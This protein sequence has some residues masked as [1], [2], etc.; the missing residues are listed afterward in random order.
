[1]RHEANINAQKPKTAC[2]QL[3]PVEHLSV[4]DRIAEGGNIQ[5]IRFLEGIF[6]YN[7]CRANRYKGMA[8]KR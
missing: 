4:G 7:E 8:V 1:M 5:S 2:A 6:D 3:P